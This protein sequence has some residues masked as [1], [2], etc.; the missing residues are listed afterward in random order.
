MNKQQL[1]NRIWAS[2]N[3][4]RNKIDANEY[5]DYILGLI[6]YKFLSDTEVKYFTEVCE[7]EEDELPELVENY[8]DINMKN[9]IKE[10]Q[11]HIGFFIEYK[12]L[13][14]TWLNDTSFSVQTLSEALSNF[15]RL[16]SDNYASVY[17]GIFKTL[18]FHKLF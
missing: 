6:F 15:E 8:E 10:C 3:N 1:A 9:A 17:D 16:M 4:M 13:F 2:P 14:T 18:L 11:E 7:W 12:Y 5:K